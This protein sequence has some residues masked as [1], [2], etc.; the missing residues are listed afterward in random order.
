MLTKPERTYNAHSFYTAAKD[1]VKKGHA[2]TIGFTASRDGSNYIQF[3]EKEDIPIGSIIVFEDDRKHDG[4]GSH[5]TVY[6][7]YKNGNHWVYQVGTANGPEMC[8]IERML[9]GP[10]PQWPLAVIVPTAIR[11]SACAKV[12]ATDQKDN[13]VAKAK[14]ILT[15]T[16][17]K[18]ITL[19]TDKKGECIKEGLAYGKYQLTVIPPKGYTCKDSS[20]KVELTPN[21][22]SENVLSISFTKILPPKKE[23]PKEQ[24]KDNSQAVSSRP[25][26]DQSSLPEESQEETSESH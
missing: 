3:K 4:K 23:P 11:F 5:I 24:S 2:R 20:S 15:Q 25:L 16:D 10:D 7:G 17:G 13:P 18:K 14:V 19:T 9:F 26:P 12:T 6:G 8:A 22:N 1:W 21:N